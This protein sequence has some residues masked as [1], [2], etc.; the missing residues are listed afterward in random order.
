MERSELVDLLYDGVTDEQAM[1]TAVQEFI[2]R[3]NSAGSQFGILHR[4]TGATAQAVVVGFDSSDL[5]AY[6]TRYSWRDPRWP[7]HVASPGEVITIP[8]NL[9]D[10]RSFDRSS[11]VND[12]LIKRDAYQSMGVAFPGN[13]RFQSYFYLM[14]SRSQGEYLIEEV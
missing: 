6:L 8:E 10:R 11:L 13:G 2:R 9:P 7:L 1:V 3:T 4:D 14:R 5:Q 12:L